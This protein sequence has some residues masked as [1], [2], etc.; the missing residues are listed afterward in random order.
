M[1]VFR[2]LRRGASRIELEDEYT[3]RMEAEWVAD[4]KRELDVQRI[5]KRY[6]AASKPLTLKSEENTPVAGLPEGWHATH[7]VFKET[8]KDKKVGGLEVITHGLITAFYICPQRSLFGFFLI[9]FMPD[10]PEDPV[11]TICKLAETFRNHTTRPVTP[12]ELFDVSFCLPGEFRLEK[13]HFDIGSKMMR[14]K[15]KSRRLHLWH[16]S[17]A[18]MF[19]KDGMTADRWATGFL[20]GYGGF[21]GIRFGPDGKG[22]ITWRRRKPF[23]FGHRSEI[24]CWCFKYDIGWKLAEETRQLVVWV[25][26]YRR[27]SDLQVLS[28]S[29]CRELFDHRAWSQGSAVEIGD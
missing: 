9:H 19:L 23:L 29:G 10:D 2:F 17:C 14:F 18:D 1:A 13:T 28:S 26:H 25:Y 27:Q 21:K 16:F 22:G 11:A 5:M 24:A 4:H 15:W 7:F 8:V 3:V 12:W 6:E 20:N